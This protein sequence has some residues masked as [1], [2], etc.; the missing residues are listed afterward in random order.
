MRFRVQTI[1]RR[2]SLREYANPYAIGMYVLHRVKDVAGMI[3]LCLNEVI[4][5][6]LNTLRNMQM[7][8]SY[9]MMTETKEKCLR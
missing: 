3:I 5:L 6:A 9:L 2:Y 8:Q 1:L 7:T 4:S